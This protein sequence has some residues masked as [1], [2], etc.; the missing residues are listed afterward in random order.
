MAEVQA[1]PAS[2]TV[3]PRKKRKIQ[4]P[5]PATEAAATIAAAAKAGLDIEGLHLHD[6]A[7]I[8]TLALDPQLQCMLAKQ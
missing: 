3:K 6:H 8:C 4:K 5:K 7:V 1:A 2:H